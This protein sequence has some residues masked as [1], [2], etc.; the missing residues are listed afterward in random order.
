[1]VTLA[2]LE[3]QPA[4]VPWSA[5]GDGGGTRDPHAQ[6]T[7]VMHLAALHGDAPC[8]LTGDTAGCLALWGE[9]EAPLAVWSCAHALQA[10]QPPA[11]RRPLPTYL[12]DY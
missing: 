3:P 1:V 7:A 10:N 6:L 8:I 11:L 12:T 2:Y 4:R 9:G 5:D